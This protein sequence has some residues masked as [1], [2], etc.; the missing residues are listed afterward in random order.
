MMNKNAFRKMA[1]TTILALLSLGFTDI[2]MAQNVQ[3]CVS[4]ADANAAVQ[5]GQILKLP[6]ALSVAGVPR[7][8]QIL[9]QQVCYVDGQLGYVVSVLESSGNTRQLVLR[10][11]DGTPYN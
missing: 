4:A 10:G 6:Q 3:Q 9:N 2:A 11:S 7:S 8:A 1:G 5:S